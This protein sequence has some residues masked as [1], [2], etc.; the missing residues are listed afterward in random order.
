V[1]EPVFLT[2]Y[3]EHDAL[4]EMTFDIR[5]AYTIYLSIIYDTP[6]H[7]TSTVLA[8]GFLTTNGPL[9]LL[10]SLSQS[11]NCDFTSENT[12]HPHHE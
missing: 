10:L 9:A 12:I 3:I 8:S 7:G 5:V 11:A 1:H 2:W 4:V 6:V